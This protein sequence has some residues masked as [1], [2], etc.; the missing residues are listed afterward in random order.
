MSHMRMPMFVPARQPC[1]ISLLPCLLEVIK[2]TSAPKLSHVSLRSFIV[3][4]RPPRFFES[5]SIILPGSICSWIRD[6]MVGP[7]VP[8]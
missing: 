4:G 3:S 1:I 2:M 6:V 5:Q 8:S 7:N